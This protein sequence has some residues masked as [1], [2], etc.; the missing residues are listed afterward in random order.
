MVKVLNRHHRPSV[1]NS[2]RGKRMV[3]DVVRLLSDRKSGAAS[4]YN[5][6]IKRKK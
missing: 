1:V 2:V 4:L 6:S 5:C 3:V